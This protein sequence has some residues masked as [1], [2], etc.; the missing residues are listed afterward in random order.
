MS[1]LLDYARQLVPG[2]LTTIALTLVIYPLAAGVAVVIAMLRVWRVPVF[3]T[4]ATGLVE[5][6]RSTPALLQLFFVYFALPFVGITLDSWPT[7][8]LTLTVHFG[9]YQS[10][11]VRAAIFSVPVGLL[12]AA[13]VLGMPRV[14]RLR[15]VTAPLAIRL[16]IPP[17]ANSLI[18]LFKATV[19]VS[20]VAVHE[21]FFVAQVL[22]NRTFDTV[23]IFL[24][25]TV[26]FVGVGYPAARF[27][28]SLEGRF[29]VHGSTRQG[30]AT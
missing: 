20:L 6:I 4:L 18:E 19:I 28:R 7:A 21:V 8:I 10:E 14:T 3:A 27:V 22:A 30:G 29:A 17:M 9:A 1:D 12:E 24:L 11:I 23:P 26:F 2:A 13:E 25:L 16:A 5:F 15:R